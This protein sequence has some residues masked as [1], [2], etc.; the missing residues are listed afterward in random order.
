MISYFIFRD[1]ASVRTGRIL[2]PRDCEVG[3]ETARS[4][5]HDDFSKSISSTLKDS[6]IASLKID[7]AVSFIL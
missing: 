4:G 7:T 1:V 6:S 2:N 5:V 3:H